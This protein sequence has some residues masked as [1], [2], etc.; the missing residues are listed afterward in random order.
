MVSKKETETLRRIETILK[1]G[2]IADVHCEG[3]STGELISFEAPLRFRAPTISIS[4]D[5][6]ISA[7]WRDDRLQDKF[8]PNSDLLNSR[9]FDLLMARIP[10]GHHPESYLT[11]PAFVFPFVLFLFILGATRRRNRVSRHHL[12]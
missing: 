1:M 12:L 10:R 3:L 9:D 4:S 8:I 5:G 7:E 2:Y 11:H 6:E